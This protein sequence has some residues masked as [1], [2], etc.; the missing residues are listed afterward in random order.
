M[1]RTFTPGTEW[2]YL[3]IYTGVKTADLILEEAIQFV[4]K[5]LQ[6]NNEISKWFLFVIMIQNRIY[7]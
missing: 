6:K 1:K 4:A 7:E 5:Y 2:L 3:K